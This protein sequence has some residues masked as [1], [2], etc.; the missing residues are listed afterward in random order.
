MVELRPDVAW[1]GLVNMR[2][3][4][5]WLPQRIGCRG[6]RGWWGGVAVAVVMAGWGLWQPAPAAAVTAG[7]TLQ[8]TCPFSQPLTAQMVWTMPA[9]IVV[10]KPVPAVTVTAAATISAADAQLLGAAGVA[11]VDGSGD[12]TGVVVA[13]EG[14]IDTALHLIV[15]PTPVPASGPMTFHAAGTT[16]S[17]VF[18]QPG[19]AVVDVGSTLDLALIPRDATGNPLGGPVSLS[20]TLNPGQNPEVSSFDITPVPVTPST[21]TRTDTPPPTR[22]TGAS[23][24]RGATTPG[25]GA[26]GGGP[27]L[28]DA[29]GAGASRSSAGGP[30]AASPAVAH[31][32]PP[33]TATTPAPTSITLMRGPVRDS[34]AVSNRRGLAAGWWWPVVGTLAVVAGVVGGVRWLRNPRRTH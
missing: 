34:A 1:C 31:S 16:D 4:F 21:T 30:R 27:S 26:S 6:R 19:H 12:T 5:R 9:A 11:S 10:G 22:A 20:C 33:S 7:V 14:S 15:S 2:L 8:Y 25:V 32:T 13:P 18:R 23:R 3:N 29:A 24:T 17:M 28:A